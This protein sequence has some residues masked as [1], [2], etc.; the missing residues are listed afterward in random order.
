MT[1]AGKWGESTILVTGDNVVVDVA[2]PRQAVTGTI[3]GRDPWKISVKFEYD[4]TFAGTLINA[5]Q[6]MW[7]KDGETESENIWM[8]TLVADGKQH[9]YEPQYHADKIT[10][11]FQAEQGREYLFRVRPKGVALAINDNVH[12]DSGNSDTYE[13]IRYQPAATHVDNVELSLSEEAGW[14]EL[15]VY[16]FIDQSMTG[17]VLPTDGTPI[18]SYA[19]QITRSRISQR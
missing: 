8:R 3:L 19:T 15:S 1:V 2:G 18:M 16:E 14:S 4:T 13:E 17:Y 6:I 11:P 5:D 12:T 7:T 9:S 10:Y